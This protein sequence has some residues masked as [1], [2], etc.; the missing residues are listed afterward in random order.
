MVSVDWQSRRRHLLPS[1]FRLVQIVYP[2][3]IV[4]HSRVEKSKLLFGKCK[5]QNVDYRTIQFLP[6]KL[7]I[8][9]RHLQAWW[10][11]KI[12]D[13][14]RVT[15]GLGLEQ[16]CLEISYRTFTLLWFRNAWLGFVDTCRLIFSM[17]VEPGASNAATW[18]CCFGLDHCAW[19]AIY[20]A[21]R[22]LLKKCV[23]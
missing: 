16:I 7:V 21:L 5:R 14:Q 6:R 18:T 22:A 13:C 2:F 1:W 9:D 4:S 17:I 3:S 8:E 15:R 23:S 12:L 20:C 10:R 11:L 19:T